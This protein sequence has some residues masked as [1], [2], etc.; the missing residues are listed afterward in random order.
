MEDEFLNLDIISKVM[1]Y[2]FLDVISD[3]MKV[4]ILVFTT[5]FFFFFL[6][7]IFV[8]HSV[9]PASSCMMAVRIKLKEN[10][11]GETSLRGWY[12][13]YLIMAFY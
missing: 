12:I 8:F 5:G 4:H 3:V 1:T 7:V 2:R 10:S 13:D 9:C 11:L 6:N